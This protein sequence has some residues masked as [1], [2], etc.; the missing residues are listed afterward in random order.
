MGT[1]FAVAAAAVAAVVLTAAPAEV[2]AQAGGNKGKKTSMKPT[3]SKSDIRRQVDTHLR[4]GIEFYAEKE[5]E[6][7]IVEFRAGFA[8]DPRPDFLF[9]L[10][11]AERLSGD[12]PT[13]VIYY[14][15]FLAT[16]PSA[17]QS[18]A[19]R[20]NM[21]RCNRALESG[22]EGPPRMRTDDALRDA[23]GVKAVPAA[24]PNPTS[25]DLAVNTPWYRDRVASSLLVA[26]V[27]SAGIGTGFWVASSSAK[28]AAD[29]AS[30]LD[31]FR[32]HMS[33]ASSRRTISLVS[34][35][36]AG[37]LIAA[38]VVRLALR[39]PGSKSKPRSASA[40]ELVAAPLSSGVMI[41]LAGRF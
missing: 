26:G 27:V 24:M 25:D 12:C 2:A 37:G 22:P 19:A 3:R 21:K 15:R 29:D 8:L 31:D 16:K 10:A 5:Y 17:K 33:A 13:A 28:S 23:E 35:A 41:G 30:N 11:Q 32:A 39:K 40:H 36:A 7:A 38:G 6:L 18:E 9:A 34:L 20:I 1:R 14:K 4:R